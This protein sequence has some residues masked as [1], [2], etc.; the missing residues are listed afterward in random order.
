MS[1]KH[2][3]FYYVRHGK[4]HYNCKRIIQGGLV[5][6]D[7]TDE[8]LYLVNDTA[9]TLQNVPFARCYASPLGRA[10]H[11]AQIIMDAQTH[12]PDKAT[13]TMTLDDRLKEISF[14]RIDGKPFEQH[15]WEFTW[16]FLRQDF[17]SLGGETH[18]ELRTR[19]R[20]VFVDM[21]KQAQDGDKILV[22]AHG[23]LVRYLVL[24]FLDAPFFKKM[25]LS[26][27]VCVSNASIGI[28]DANDD[29][30]SLSVLPLSSKEFAAQH[31]KLL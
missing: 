21:Y 26:R 28:I 29:H 30:F 24:E 6:S 8:H 19:M 10:V 14:G 18:H 22:V 12:T 13:P 23:G 25:Y 3:T 16:A 2:V 15:K 7:L 17:R 27:C 11:T 31:P 4:T 20:Q 9:H 5:D 1:K